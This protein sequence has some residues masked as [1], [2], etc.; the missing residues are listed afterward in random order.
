MIC[1]VR[2]LIA[3]FAIQAAVE[4]LLAQ[5]IR[6]DAYGDPLPVGAVARLGTI[7]L[8]R[9]KAV[10]DVCFVDSE[11]Q[12][13]VAC[14]EPA[15]LLYHADDYAPSRRLLHPGDAFRLEYSAHGELAVSCAG[16]QR[17]NVTVDSDKTEHASSVVV[18][19]R[20]LKTLIQVIDCQGVRAAEIAWSPNGEL[21]LIAAHQEK[22]ISI[23]SR[24]EGRT[25]AEVRCPGHVQRF[26]WSPDGERFAASNWTGT[27]TSS[28]IVW[29]RNGV[30][31]QQIVLDRH[32]PLSVAF[33]AS[34]PRLA[35]GT[36]SPTNQANE[37]PILLWNLTRR[38]IAAHL[39]GHSQSVLS[40]QL[41]AD[42]KSLWSS[43]S[44]G[45]IRN[46]S[47]EFLREDKQI[48]ATTGAVFH[49]MRFAERNSTLLATHTLLGASIVQV[50]DVGADPPYLRWKPDSH[51]G[52]VRGIGF[53]SDCSRLLTL[54]ADGKVV[55]WDWKACSALQS[56]DVNGVQQAAFID[57]DKAVVIATRN[58]IQLRNVISGKL[59]APQIAG[60]GDVLTSF[61][62]SEVSGRMAI[63]E[64]T[65]YSPN[66]SRP[67]EGAI[68]ILD[69]SSL[70]YVARI[71]CDE[72][73]VLSY[74]ADGK[75]LANW[76][77]EPP[78]RFKDESPA[79]GR[80]RAFVATWGT[81]EFKLRSR[82]ETPGLVCEGVAF[83]ADA[84]KL[85][86]VGR[87]RNPL[88]SWNFGQAIATSQ[89]LE[90]LTEHPNAVCLTEKWMAI[91]RM[92]SS[93]AVVDLA[94]G[95]TFQIPASP[96]ERCSICISPDGRYVAQA[97]LSG[98]TL[99]WDVASSNPMKFDE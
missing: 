73:D 92:P 20:D 76:G 6:K 52:P 38:E 75:Y 68:A 97:S 26:A 31:E 12:V 47:L 98:V 81:E 11:Q 3:I 85:W 82:V 83:S 89:L 2:V 86:L 17:K 56:W 74:S 25:V 41:S 22:T 65:Q 30:E 71:P 9:D 69:T 10:K 5:E 27:R 13:A 14:G 53:S 67:D 8:A 95:G 43:S 62:L 46:W 72:V 44:D 33:C 7:R 28:V 99:V 39:S 23:W 51:D 94:G 16:R 50:W 88:S 54:G 29:S 64:R 36:A 96:T 80:S 55:A 84:S 66:D 78:W 57:R 4:S 61:A 35:I 93:I 19:A 58:A 1:F 48:K 79:R 42:G 77:T 15:V 21:L 60:S 32:F 63:G 70:R 91:A 87:S 37:S 40:L 24:K 90:S 59:I 49:R 34:E 45:T 18:W